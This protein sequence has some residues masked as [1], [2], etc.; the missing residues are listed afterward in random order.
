M[1]YILNFKFIASNVLHFNQGENNSFI[2]KNCLIFL[3][4]S[5]FQKSLLFSE[6]VI[7]QTFLRYKSW[8]LSPWVTFSR[9]RMFKR[10]TVQFR[11]WQ[12][13]TIC[14]QKFRKWKNKLAIYKIQTICA[15]CHRL[16][17][18]QHTGLRNSKYPI[19]GGW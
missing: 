16:A 6:I 14:I 19:M 5:F 17:A 3:F 12:M 11:C 9:M 7:T 13:N 4:L 18:I 10:K 2:Q 8:Y 1:L 15:K